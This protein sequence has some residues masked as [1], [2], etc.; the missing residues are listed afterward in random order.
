MFR[1]RFFPHYQDVWF[2]FLRYTFVLGCHTVYMF[3]FSLG[4]KSLLQC[5]ALQIVGQSVKEGWTLVIVRDNVLSNHLPGSKV[6]NDC[7]FFSE[8]SWSVRSWQWLNY[9]TFVFSL[10]EVGVWWI[11]NL[12]V[13]RY[14]DHITIVSIR[15]T[16]QALYQKVYNHIWFDY[17]TWNIS[18]LNLL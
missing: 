10:W 5:D 12:I 16:T 14:L 9:C 7:I 6:M 1:V 8:T 13:Y 2:G 15:F 4:R 11:S 17:W 18:F 3:S